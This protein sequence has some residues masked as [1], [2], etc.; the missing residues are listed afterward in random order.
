MAERG[1]ADRTASVCVTK[2]YEAW[3]R[4]APD[5]GHAEDGLDGHTR[6]IARQIARRRRHIAA[7]QST[8]FQ[9]VA[10]VLDMRKTL[11]K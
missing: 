6:Q 8:T 7:R 11:E 2:L 1:S 4:L 9:R 3:D 10:T 5:T